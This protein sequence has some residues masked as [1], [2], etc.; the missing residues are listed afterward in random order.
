MKCSHCGTEFTG[1]Y[2]PACGNRVQSPR[3]A[4]F[5]G[6]YRQGYPPTGGLDMQNPYYNQPPYGAGMPAPAKKN[7][8]G[9]MIVLCIIGGFVVVG[10]LALLV[11]LFTNKIGP[12]KSVAQS[13]KAASEAPPTESYSFH[14]VSFELPDRWK[15]VNSEDD[16]TLKAFTFDTAGLFTLMYEQ[17]LSFEDKNQREKFIRALY[18][19]EVKISSEKTVYVDWDQGY[20]YDVTYHNSIT[21]KDESIKLLLFDSREGGAIAAVMTIPNDDIEYHAAFDD[22]VASIEMEGSGDAGEMI[23]LPGGSARFSAVICPLQFPQQL[24]QK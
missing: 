24:S 4:P 22:I 17:D 16:G 1:E 2:C 10:L 8:R 23:S 7:H 14:D 5:Q 9:L 18:I 21:K 6:D 3:R 19:F 15:E 13:S 11:L 12:G 20:Q